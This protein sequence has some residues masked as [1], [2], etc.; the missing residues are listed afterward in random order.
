MT[1]QDRISGAY[2]VLGL[3]ESA[4]AVLV[5]LAH[6]AQARTLRSYP[7]IRTIAREC[8]IARNTAR[9]ALTL[10]VAQG[11]LTITSRRIN[12]I[13]YAT[14]EYQIAR[15]GA[16]KPAPKGGSMADPGGGSMAGQRTTTMHS[17][18]ARLIHPTPRNVVALFPEARK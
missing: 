5:C 14:N 12:R 9:S 18:K 17:R 16:F 1:H 4:K 15:R 11:W 8:S 7:S 6:H 13:R 10:L 3:S 2:A